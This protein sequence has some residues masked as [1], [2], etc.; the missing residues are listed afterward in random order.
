MNKAPVV[1]IGLCGFGTVGQGVWKH[2]TRAQTELNQ[3]LGVRLLLHRVAVRNLRKSRPVRI[4][5]S[6]LT[7]N[8]MAVATDPEI[9]IVCELIGGTE[10]AREITLAALRLGKS[11]I[12]ANKALICAHGAE[13]FATARK[14][15]GHFFFEAS[16]AGGVPIIKALREGLV[17]NR[18][19]RIYGILNGT[20]N[21]ILTQM[22]EQDAPYE[23]VLAEAKRL[24]YAE[25][26]EAL[27][28][29]GWDAAHK[30]AVLA[31]LAHGVWV[32]PGQMVVEGIDR[33][34]PA[35]FKNAATLGYGIK[36]LA[37]IVRD[38]TA[39]ELSVRVHPTLLPDG[40][41]IANVSGVFNAISVTGDVVGT[42][43]YIGR[44]AGQD[45]TA[46][47]VISDIADAA[48]LLR[49]GRGAV[50]IADETLPSA[51]GCRLA[52]PEHIKCRYY[53]RLSVK[54]QPGVLARVAS[55][56]ARHHISIAS[57][58]QNPAE[59]TNAASLVLTTHQSHERAMHSTLRD[60]ARLASV[61]D[62]PVL[63]RIGDFND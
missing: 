10:L 38:F 17:A 54:D 32:K 25:A 22:E 20:C 46:S 56:M 45:A 48:A 11:V 19:P 7:T 36:L 29:Q 39:N 12:S 49:H 9:Q 44:G 2:L 26:D 37:V 61:I 13:I 55:V 34:T 63:L 21:Y 41:V 43:L 35:D 60:L 50:L 51:N 23:G 6:R 33:I 18:F 5:A 28:V 31:W 47:A 58:I 3:R 42:T 59:I 27:D 1:K 15:G 57:V 8:A 4:P 24:G 53:L 52:P 16:V 40:N 30:A 62:R 14:H